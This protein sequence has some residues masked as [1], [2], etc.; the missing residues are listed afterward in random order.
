M[1]SELDTLQRLLSDTEVQRDDLQ[2]QLV[3][4][5]K[6]LDLEQKSTHKSKREIMKYEDTVAHLNTVLDKNYQET[7][8]IHA[9]VR[10]VG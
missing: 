3:L 2:A 10:R 9:Q 6:E 4:N 8:K 5:Q 7:R 1:K